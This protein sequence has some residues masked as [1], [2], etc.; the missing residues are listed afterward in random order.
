MTTDAPTYPVTSADAPVSGWRRAFGDWLVVGSATTVCHGLGIATSLLLKVL[1]SPAQMGIW[2]AMK[3]FLS[4][5]NYASL[6]IS[7]GA[8]REFNVALG[9]GDTSA[10]R[11]GLHLAFTVNTLTSLLYA[12]VLVGVGIWIAA[13]DGAWAGG[14]GL[15]LAAAGVMAVVGRY[16]SF[17][18]TILRTKQAFAATSQLSIIEGLLTLGLCIPAVW[19]FGLPGLYA[20]TLA[21]MLCSL[22]F[23]LRHSGMSL[24]WA[25]DMAETRRLIG[26]GGPILLAGAAAS[27]FRSLDKLMIL[28]YLN[29]REYQLGCYSLALMVGAQ[30]FGLG[31]MLSMVM[32]PRYGE[33]FG[34]SGDRRAVARLAARASELHAAAMALPAALALIAAVPLLRWL[35]PAYQAGLAPIDWLAPGA[36]AL[37]LALPASQY[38]VAVG[39]QRRA[40]VVVLIA[41]AVAALGNHLALR[42][43][44]GLTGVAAATAVGYAVYFVSAVSV[45]FWIELDAAARLRYVLT[46][47]LALGPTLGTALWLRSVRPASVDAWPALA[48]DILLVIAVWLL[49]VAIGWH[50]G[51]WKRQLK[52]TGE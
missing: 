35:L 47:I 39:R 41:T 46:H 13:G 3:M 32:G 2:Q 36:V 7:K 28:G 8:V 16:V 33:L 42:T 49:T 25:W 18:V 6:G 17:H 44:Y 26:I 1:L 27:L 5:G 40:L 19:Y 11:R 34:R 9:T 23:I 14:W 50:H 30:L 43:G 29:D 10:A 38:L 20:A 52:S 48:V 45:S 24:R 4:Y 37:V 15:A 51:G 12:A 22:A 31:N 21:V